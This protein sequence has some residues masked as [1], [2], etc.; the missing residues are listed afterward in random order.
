MANVVVV[1]TQW[2]DEGKGKIVDLLTDSAHAVVRFQGGNNA[3]HTLVV[4]GEKFIVHLIPSGILHPKKKSYIGNGVVVD[5]DVLIREI[6]GLRARGVKISPANLLLSEKA[7]LIMPY[8]AALDIARENKKGRSK[9]GT[10]GRG[11]GPCYEDKAARV[12]IRA[13]DLLDRKGFLKKLRENLEVKNFLLEKYYGA[14]PVSSQKVARRASFWAEFLAPFITNVVDLVNQAGQKGQNLLFEGAQGTHLDIDHGTYPYVTSSNPVA[15]TVCAG[16]GLPPKS[17]TSV[18]GLVKAY[19]TRVGG[20]PFPTELKEKV[21]KHLRDRGVEFGSTTGRPRR[22]GWLDMVVLN[23]SIKLSGID[24]LAITK[25]DVL[26]GLDKINICTGYTLNGKKIKNI[27]ADLAKFEKC[28]P[29]YLTMPGWKEDI[30]QARKL[31]DL[32]KAAQNYLEKISQLTGVT[33]GLVSVGPERN[34]TILLKNPF[35]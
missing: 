7:H 32:P 33:L 28:K 3:G 11:I 19:T 17:V 18:V 10:T 22:C 15:G 21:G 5:P 16:A 6:E 8:H 23:E 14:E 34:E 25:L 13:V 26:T 20:G 29:V 4:S 30:S 2:G 9:I 31:K 12:G 27:P 24:N 1:G 35:K